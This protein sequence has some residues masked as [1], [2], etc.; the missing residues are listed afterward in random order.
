[1]FAAHR[2]A[3]LLEDRIVGRQE[4]QAVENRIAQRA[5]RR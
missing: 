3:G 1:M 2:L 4:A 5:Q